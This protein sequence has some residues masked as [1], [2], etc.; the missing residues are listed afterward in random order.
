M[1]ANNYVPLGRDG[2]VATRDY[3]SNFTQIG[4]MTMAEMVGARMRAQRAFNDF[5]R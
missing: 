3:I 5:D 1:L 2:I 4:G